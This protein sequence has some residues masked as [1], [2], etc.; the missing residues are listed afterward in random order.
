MSVPNV[1]RLGWLRHVPLVFALLAVG[2]DMRAAYEPAT[3]ALA[4]DASVPIA[5]LFV[6]VSAYLYGTSAGIIAA[7]AVA[8]AD[9]GA[10]HLG[11][12]TRSTHPSITFALY[13]MQTVV[14]GLIGHLRALAARGAVD[15]SERRLVETRL[16][17]LATHDP[18]TGLPNRVLLGRRLE[19]AMATAAEPDASGAALLFIDLD[20]FKDVNDALGHHAG[21]LLLREVAAR[22]RLLVRDSD[23]VARLGGDEFAVLLLGRDSDRAQNVAERVVA[24]LERPFSLDGQSVVVSASVGIA[25]AGGDADGGTLLRHADVAMYAAKRRGNGVATY[26]ATEDVQAAHR[27]A[28]SG[29][30]R[31]AIARNELLL[32]FQPQIDVKTGNVRGVEALV[33]WQHPTRGLIF[34]DAFIPI[35][36]EIGMMDRLTDWVLHAAIRQ[37]ERWD[38]DGLRLRMAVNLSAQDLRDERLEATLAKLLASHCVDARQLCLELTETTVTTEAERAA[39]RLRGLARRGIRISIDDFGTGYSSLALLRK[40]PVDEL[41]IDKQ[42]VIGMES[43]SDDA[44]IVYSTIELAHRLR[45]DVVVEG[46]EHA[47]TLRTIERL[48]ADYAQGYA[49]SRPLPAATFESWLREYPHVLARGA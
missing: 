42:F 39:E 34:P 32:H 14:G 3:A 30:L 8:V 43:D 13:V 12:G 44:A 19:H 49:I 45:V 17:E 24:A 35:A 16:R 33:R 15:G 6:V 25:F 20:R 10:A 1:R 11:A 46:V 31:A 21:D 28:M 7:V 18:L 23:L 41:K 29:D 26:A 38:S 47:S 9:A 48:R 22:L 4:L 36:E 2:A 5:F 27:L 40:F 37:L